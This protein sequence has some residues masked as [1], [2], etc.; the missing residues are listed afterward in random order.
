MKNALIPFLSHSDFS[1]L[2]VPGREKK[3]K[4]LVRDME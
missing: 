1:R 3:A 2:V 4:I